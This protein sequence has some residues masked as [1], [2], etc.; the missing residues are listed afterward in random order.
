MFK[1]YK[2]YEKDQQD[3]NQN[4]IELNNYID[5]M[6]TDLLFWIIFYS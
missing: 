1:S 3:D 4:D 6:I 5:M 2:S